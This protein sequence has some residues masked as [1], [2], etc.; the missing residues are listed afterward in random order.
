M[1]GGYIRK[2]IDSKDTSDAKIFVTLLV[3]AHF[4]ITSFAASIFVFLLTLIKTKGTVDLNL[5][6]FLSEIIDKDFYILLGGLGFVTADGYRQM[7]L[8]KAKVY[9]AAK[10]LTPPTPITKVQNVEGDMNGPN[11]GDKKET[12]DDVLEDNDMNEIKKNLTN[13]LK[14]DE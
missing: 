2:L 11:A 12:G 14:S 10:I 6:A 4:M 9:S 5:L 13:S 3:A 1:K 8:E 7:L